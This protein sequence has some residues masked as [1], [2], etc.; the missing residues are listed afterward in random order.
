MRGTMMEFPLLLPTI[1][2]RAGKLFGSTEIVS[3]L[4]DR[5][6]HR[7]TYKDFSGRARALAAALQQAGIRKGERVAS[8]MLNHHAHLEA[9][10][11]VPASGAVLHTLNLRLHADE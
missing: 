8:L 11:G 2:E 6:L 10:F 4:P 9:Y 7:Y 3:R 5:S 1:L